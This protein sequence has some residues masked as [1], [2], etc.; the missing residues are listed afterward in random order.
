M[1]AISLVKPEPANCS[2][3]LPRWWRLVLVGLSAI[4]LSA[5]NSTQPPR[6]AINPMRMGSPQ[7]P[8]Q[9]FTGGPGDYDV[10]Q[11]GYQ[12]PSDGRPLPLTCMCEAGDDANLPWAPPGIR[13]PWPADE[14][15]CDGGD[16]NVK[17]GVAADFTV[18][19]LD[20]EDTVAH[21]DTKDG[22]III[23][24]SNKVCIYAPRF[25]SVRK[26]DPAGLS[27]Q[28]VN[29]SGAQSPL[30]AIVDADLGIPTTALQQLPPKTDIATRRPIALRDRQRHHTLANE[31]SPR[32]FSDR[33]KAHE[34]L[35]VIKT[36]IYQQD[37]K[38]YLAKRTLAAI[39][40]TH[41]QGAQVIINRKKAMVFDGD[42]RAEATFTVEE[43]K[44][45]KLRVIKCASTDGAVPGDVIDFTIRYDNVGDATIGNVTIV[46][47]LTT[48]LEYVP[49]SA[50]SSRKAKFLTQ[51]NEG[52]SLVLRW[53]VDEPLPPGQ[54][55][56]LRFQCVVR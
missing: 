40:W 49:E 14:Y 56:I 29:S 6:G 54:G 52:D 9:A 42:R 15:L 34:N 51:V 28:V 39:A 2:A 31:L 20:Q 25:A 3:V 41:E 46:D 21:A 12:A 27:E 35:Q 36:G 18:Y 50:Q 8:P 26:I 22:R 47:N 13:R 23:E 48:R 11:V 10:S 53:E 5:C 4:I 37:E 32:S 44:N 17:V 55:G 19:G 43:P 16:K 38:A 24:P 30:K 1:N 7:L 45:P 33:F